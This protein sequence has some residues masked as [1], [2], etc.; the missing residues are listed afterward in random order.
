V[1]SLLAAAPMAP[2]TMIATETAAAAAA[3]VPSV[4]R[5]PPAGRMASFDATVMSRGSSLVNHWS[6]SVVPSNMQS[7]TMVPLGSA[8]ADVAPGVTDVHHMGWGSSNPNP[9]TC[10]HIRSVPD[11]VTIR[12]VIV[13]VEEHGLLMVFDNPNTWTHE[14][15]RGRGW[16]RHACVYGHPHLAHGDRGERGYRDQN[17]NKLYFF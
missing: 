17:K 3:G 2:A 8:V 10:V 15:Q 11:T 6:T 1:A 12:P 16:S 5:V 13:I 9:S 7:T 14:G 4:N